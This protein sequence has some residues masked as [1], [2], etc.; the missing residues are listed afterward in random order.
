MAMSL[1][2]GSYF[3]HGPEKRKLKATT[4]SVVSVGKTKNMT[5]LG[6]MVSRCFFL[7]STQ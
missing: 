5:K 4:E 7:I 2:W 3:S 6:L 1:G